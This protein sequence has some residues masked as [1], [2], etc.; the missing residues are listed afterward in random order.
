MCVFMHAEMGSV[1]AK[2]A[3][4]SHLSGRF[5]GVCFDDQSCEFVCKVES[6]G[7]TGGACD[8]FPARCYCQTQCPP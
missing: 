1:G 6:E 8:D 2:R 3:A 4:C 5:S 7:N